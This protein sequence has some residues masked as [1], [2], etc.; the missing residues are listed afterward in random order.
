MFVPRKKAARAA[1]LYIVSLKP[2]YTSLTPG[3]VINIDPDVLPRNRSLRKIAG[4]LQL[5]RRRFFPS[6]SRLLPPQ[7]AVKKKYK[8]RVRSSYLLLRRYDQTSGDPEIF[9]RAAIRQN[10]VRTA[11]SSYLNFTSSVNWST[12]Y[13]G[14]ASPYCRVCLFKSIRRGVS[15]NVTRCIIKTRRADAARYLRTLDLPP[16][17]TRSESRLINLKIYNRG[18]FSQRLKYPFLI[19]DCL[20]SV[21]TPQASGVRRNAR[22]WNDQLFDS[23]EASSLDANFSLSPSLSAFIFSGLSDASSAFLFLPRNKLKLSISLSR[24]F[25]KNTVGLHVLKDERELRFKSSR[26]L[27]AANSAKLFPVVIAAPSIQVVIAVKGF[28]I[29]RPRCFAARCSESCAPRFGRARYI[30]EYLRD[31]ALLS[32]RTVERR[33]R[34]S[35]RRLKSTVFRPPRDLSSYAKRNFRMPRMPH[36][37]LQQ[38]EGGEEVYYRAPF[39]FFMVQK[40]SAGPFQIPATFATLRDSRARFARPRIA[41]FIS[42]YRKAWSAEKEREEDFPSA[43]KHSR[44]TKHT[45]L[46]LSLSICTRFSPLIY[47]IPQSF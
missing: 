24:R 22:N 41:L 29:S 27:R 33:P 31:I 42:R 17:I 16:D 38:R 19:H 46:C 1:V 11:S 26:Q 6:P 5:S 30:G 4:N 47:S 10:A 32:R 28:A 35:E 14:R 23:C 36:R 3:I 45:S 9:M 15:D 2:N 37:A 21:S 39:R 12:A 34:A 20:N 7:S 25:L 40:R 18:A 43:P 8:V 44:Y 13:R